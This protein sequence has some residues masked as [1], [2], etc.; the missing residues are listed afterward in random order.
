MKKLL[1]IL[2]I[3]SL[4]FSLASCKPKDKL[5][6]DYKLSDLEGEITNDIEEGLDEEAAYTD[7]EDVA[8]YIHTFNKLPKN[9]IKKKDAMALGWEAN[10]GNLWEVTDQMSIGGDSFGN[11]EGL[12]PNKDGRKYFECDINYQGDFRGPERIVYSNDGLIFYTDDHYG[13]F[14][15]LYG[16]E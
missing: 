15:L 16:D 1:S 3:L 9:F 13:S 11:R 5:L 2:L 7:K 12:L 14:T 8:L 6:E 4:V 10:K